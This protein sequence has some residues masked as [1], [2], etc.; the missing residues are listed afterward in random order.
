M[1]T[2]KAAKICINCSWTFYF[3]VQVCPWFVLLGCPL[4]GFEYMW[5]EGFL[6][7]RSIMLDLSYAHT[8]ISS[9]SYSIISWWNH[10]TMWCDKNIRN[11]GRC[12]TNSKLSVHQVHCCQFR[13]GAVLCGYRQHSFQPMYIEIL[14]V[15]HPSINTSQTSK[16]NNFKCV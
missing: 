7:L 10:S 8:E 14:L 4:E 6:S 2:P 9:R 5:K 16:T 13:L 15:F 11:I 3:V 1:V 12:L